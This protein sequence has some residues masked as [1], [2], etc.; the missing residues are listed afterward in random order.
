MRDSFYISRVT[1]NLVKLIRISLNTITKILKNQ[2]NKNKRV[3]KNK[4]SKG[5]YFSIKKRSQQIDLNE[6]IQKFIMENVPNS[7]VQ[8]IFYL[9][10]LFYFIFL[11][12][13]A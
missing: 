11:K 13:F 8:G 1:F 4:Y 6:I 10:I 7:F 3:I 2:K 5:L 9:P 12:L